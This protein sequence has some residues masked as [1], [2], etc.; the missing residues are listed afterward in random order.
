MR[1]TVKKRLA[2]YVKTRAFMEQKRIRET[3]RTAADFQ[4]FR[5]ATAITLVHSVAKVTAV[6]GGVLQRTLQ[7]AHAPVICSTAMTT[8]AEASTALRE[9][10]FQFVASG[11]DLTLSPPP[12]LCAGGAK[13]DLT[14]FTLSSPPKQCEGGAKGVSKV[15][16]LGRSPN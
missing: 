15:G 3:A 2:M 8:L 12:K 5:A 1:N 4:V 7:T 6:T 11:I 10:G 16:G 14:I 9:E 13:G